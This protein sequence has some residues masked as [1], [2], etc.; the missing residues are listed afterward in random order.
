MHNV[1]DLKSKIGGGYNKFWNNKN[2]YRVVKGSRGS[3]KSRTTALNFIYR[4]MKYE[5]SNLLVV[6][7]FSNTNKQSTYTDLKW[8]TNQLGVAHLFKFN[9]SLPEITYKPTGQ[10]ILFRGLDDPLKI[11]SITVDV[12]ILCWA[13]FEEAYQIENFDKFSTVVESI[14]GSLDEPEF[15]K[16]ITVTFNPWSER[17]WLKPTFFDEDTRLKNVYSN[18]TTFRVN[19]WLDKVDVDRYEDLYR[20]NPRRARIVCDGEW[21]VAEGLVYDNFVVEDFDWLQIYKKTQFKVH[22]IDYGFTNDPTALVSAVVDL[23]NKILWLYDEHYE[24]GMLSDDIYKMIVKKDLETA[25]IKSEN[26]MR[27]IAE[28]KNKGVKRIVPAVK[29][30]HS[31]MPGIQYVQGFKI[32]IHPSCV[33]TI[34]EFNTYTFEQDNEGNWINKPIDKNNHALDALR[35]ALS[36]LIFKSKKND[37]NTLRKIKSMF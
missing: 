32:Y 19:E 13:W 21:G 20:T 10:K 34:E 14:R 28:L 3:K 7:R 29:G 1:I 17:H 22:G 18:T 35:Y 26:D 24:K 30:P 36:D 23:D 31:I 4:L 11:T 15:F 16:Q 33:H 9:E 37:K 2:F 8:A 12:G 25:E 5:W 27:M 6:R